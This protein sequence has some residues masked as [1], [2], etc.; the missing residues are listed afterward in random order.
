MTARSST[1]PRRAIWIFECDRRKIWEDGKEGERSQVTRPDGDRADDGQQVRILLE[2]VDEREDM[3]PAL[4]PD[5]GKHDKAGAGEEVAACEGEALQGYPMAT[6]IIDG[7]FD[8]F[9]RK[10]RT[11]GIH[12]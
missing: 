1:P 7:P 5:V 8:D 3:V 6:Q 2:E 9:P 4:E 12:V 11:R 10:T